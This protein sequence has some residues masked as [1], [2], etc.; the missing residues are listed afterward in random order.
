VQRLIPEYGTLRVIALS[1]QR[2]AKLLRFTLRYPGF[3][4]YKDSLSR[5]S[6]RPINCM[7]EAAMA[8]VYRV[9]AL[10]LENDAGEV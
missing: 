9:I 5:S 6:V 8:I 3:G 2:L 7:R 10:L 4:N 1:L